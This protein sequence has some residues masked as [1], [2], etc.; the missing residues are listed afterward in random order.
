MRVATGSTEITTGSS[1]SRDGLVGRAAD[2]DDSPCRDQ[3]ATES[4]VAMALVNAAYRAVAF[5]GSAPES[6]REKNITLDCGP[7][8]TLLDT[9]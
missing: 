5:T 9:G 4:T 6:N 3:I 1:T 8:L 7:E 2:H